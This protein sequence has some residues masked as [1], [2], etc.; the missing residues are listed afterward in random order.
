MVV[1]KSGLFLDEVG[2]GCHVGDRGVLAMDFGDYAIVITHNPD[3]DT[4]RIKL[5]SCAKWVTSRDWL[6]CRRKD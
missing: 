6:G 4:T 3:N 1:L 2:S 5:L